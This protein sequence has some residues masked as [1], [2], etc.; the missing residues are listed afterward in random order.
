[1]AY[2]LDKRKKACN[3]ND[4]VVAIKRDIKIAI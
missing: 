3:N 4:I 1:M 2:C